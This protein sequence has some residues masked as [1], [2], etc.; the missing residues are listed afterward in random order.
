MPPANPSPDTPIQPPQSDAAALER[1]RSFLRNDA[2]AK[3]LGFELVDG[4]IGRATL[5]MKITADHLNFYRTVHGGVIF[6]LADGAFGFACN[7]QGEISMAIGNHVTFT[8]SGGLGETLTATAIEASKSKNIATYDVRVQNGNGEVISTMTGTAY[9]S[10]MP[11][12][13]FK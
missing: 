8:K 5:R 12:A 4:G 10:G 3:V 2:F 13:E 9:R 6:A 7:S 11:V 1:I